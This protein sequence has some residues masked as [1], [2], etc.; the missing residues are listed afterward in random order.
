MPTWTKEQLSAINEEGKNII[1]SAG[2]GSGKTAVLSER[3]LRKL[4]EGININELLILTFT[5]AAA[6]EMKERIRKKIK[7]DK[8]LLKQLNL[9]D[10]SY[11]TT[12]DSFA[13][14]TVKKYHYLINV[15]PNICVIDA[16]LIRLEKEKILDEILNEKYI[17]EDKLFEKLIGDF[18]V[19]DDKEIKNYILNINDKLD[20]KFDKKTYLQN[21]LKVAFDECK[22]KEDILKFENILKSKIDEI[23]ILLEDLSFI[24]DGEYFYTLKDDLNPLLESHNYDEILNNLN[25][26]MSKLPGGSSAEVKDLK[27]RISNILKELKLLCKYKNK[28]EI[29]SQIMSTY[30][31]VKCIIEII[32]EL[33]EKIYEYKFKNDM[34]EFNDIAILSIKILKENEDVREELKNQFNEIMIDEYQDTND[35]Q[36]EFISLISNNNVYMVGDIKQ[37]IYRFRNANPYIFKNKYDNYKDD[38]GGFKID[39][40]KNFRSRKEV[41]DNINRIFEVMMDNTLG[42]AEYKESHEMIFGNISYDE[43]GNV[44]QNNNLEIYNYNYDK[45][46]IYT[47]EEIEAFIIANDI[48]KKIQSKYR[49]FDKDDFII[50]EANYNDFVILMDKSTNFPLYKKIFEYLGIPLTIYK[51]EKITEDIVLSIL[52]NI[53]LLIQKVHDKQYDVKFKYLFISIS[54]SPLFEISDNEIFNYFKNNNF[55]ENELYKLCLELSK[56]ID[57][58]SIKDFINLVINK[59]NFYE[60]IIKIGNIN[61]NIIKLDYILNITDSFSSLGYTIKEFSNYLEEIIEKKYDIK[62]NENKEIGN[63]VKIMTIH[64]SKGLEYHICYYPGLY[65]KFNI[66]DLNDKFMFDNKYGIISP[67]FDEGID[68]TIYKELLKDNYIKEEISEKIRLFYVGLTRTK[69]K[70]ILLCNLD[71]DE[72]Y[73]KKENGVLKDIFRVKYRSFKDMILSVKEYLYDYITNINVDEINITKDYNLIK[74]TNYLEFIDKTDEK[75][76]VNEINIETENIEEKSFSKKQNELID[77]ITKENIKLGLDMHSIFEIVDFKNPDLDKLSIDEFYKNKILKFLDNDI[78]KNINKAKIYKEYEFMYKKDNISYHGIIDLMLVYDN[79]VDIID[80]KLKNIDDEKYISQLNGY[81]DY[82]KSKTGREVDI[83]LY[84]IMN[85]EIKKVN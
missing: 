30:D 58:M 80:Y 43:K 78:F 52:K 11:I 31:Y 64:K 19:K 75:L 6:K 46:G 22:V 44:N 49:V 8:S 70:M 62:F 67:V 14:S 71:S 60:N 76:S 27:T 38:I 17:K 23:E 83:Y 82:I 5:K 26:S 41:L 4:K 57:N 51:D 3:V 69:E 32:L 56:Y 25:V 53:L 12:F 18:C 9:I 7:N 59:F 40:N 1:V 21:Y 72:I 37:S 77:K 73:N 47:K 84:S 63:S 29:Y 16:S 55:K 24:T 35:I 74:N 36:E 68:S 34:F 2:A 39:L 48:K 81:K 42:G 33:D 15:S 66:S 85:D 10:A 79:R 28:D 13:L 20:L 54:R 61:S 45:N 65:S 50:R